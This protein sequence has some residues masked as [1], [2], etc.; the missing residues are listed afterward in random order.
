MNTLWARQ[1]KQRYIVRITDIHTH[2]RYTLITDT[3]I[4]P[5]FQGTRRK[6]TE[7]TNTLA[8]V[9]K[10][11]EKGHANNKKKTTHTHTYIYEYVYTFS[12]NL[13]LI[14]IQTLTSPKQKLWCFIY[15][16]FNA[17]RNAR[18]HIKTI[19][20]THSQCVNTGQC[21]ESSRKV[22]RRLWDLIILKM[23][24]TCRNM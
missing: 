8:Y 11:W 18:H 7:K 3:L 5:M 1:Q 17:F 2:T 21:R 12:T 10:N 14:L 23:A 6:R 19:H 24:P 16:I 15:S 9:N 4:P 13:I 20:T 22:N